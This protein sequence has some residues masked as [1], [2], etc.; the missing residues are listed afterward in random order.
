MSRI[1]HHCCGPANE[2]RIA[3]AQVKNSSGD[4][5]Q[6]IAY[7]EHLRTAFMVV[8]PLLYPFAFTQSRV[9]H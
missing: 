7:W 6:N 4:K 3:R 5:S 8:T 1:T 2:Y 9:L